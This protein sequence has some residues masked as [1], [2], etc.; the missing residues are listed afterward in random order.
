MKSLKEYINE[1]LHHDLSIIYMNID[2]SGGLYDGEIQLAS[3]IADN[4]IETYNNNRRKFDYELQYDANDLK[5][6]ENIF[7]NS[8]II[9]VK[10]SILGQMF[11]TI[12]LYDI[13]NSDEKCNTKNMDDMKRFFHKKYNYLIDE[14]R[15]DKIL[16]TISCN[17]NSKY[18]DIAGRIAH[19]LNHAYT[20]WDML[21]DDLSQ[22]K[23]SKETFVPEKYH[24]ALHI[25]SNNIYNKIISGLKINDINDYDTYRN[26]SYI[27]LYSLTIF[28]RNA[29]MAEMLSYLFNDDT[30]INRVYDIENLLLKSSQYDLYANK[31]PNKISEIENDWTV[32]QQE[33]LR[34]IYNEIYNCN[35]SFNKIMHIIKFKL[36]ETLKRLNKNIK[37][38]CN[39]KKYNSE[40]SE[41][42]FIS[43]DLEMNKKYNIEWF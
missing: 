22:E 29:F 38:L 4:I 23:I 21:T 12:D 20:Y 1:N 10:R 5:N 18:E 19:E 35:K 8:I 26:A 14:K 28:E 36:N 25:F 24:N 16:I 41:G 17:I 32:E 9:N 33:T 42:Q 30:K 34:N 3:F 37:I 13:K 40:I 27:L 2:E 39:M 43:F 6:F 31:T 15:L 11:S 7:F